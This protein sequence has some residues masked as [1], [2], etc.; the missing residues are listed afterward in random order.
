MEISHQFIDFFTLIVFIFFKFNFLFFSIL[1]FNCYLKVYWSLNSIEF[2]WIS[3][4]DV[5]PSLLSNFCFYIITCVFLLWASLGVISIPTSF[6]FKNSLYFLAIFLI[7]FSNSAVSFSLL[8]FFD[9]LLIF[10]FLLLS[11]SSKL[12]SLSYPA[13]NFYNFLISSSSSITLFFFSSIYYSLNLLF[14]SCLNFFFS[15]LYG[16]TAFLILRSLP[17]NSFPFKDSIACL[18]NGL[19]VNWIY[20]IPL[21]RWVNES[22]IT[23][24]FKMPSPYP[25]NPALSDFETPAKCLLKSSSF[26]TKGKFPIN[27]VV[28]KSF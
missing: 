10:T 1:P 8:I 26:N 16:A 17:I 7:W 14:S 22:L 9:L 15:N 6:F 3:N 20:A 5:F 2:L 12:S 27:I 11:S 23:L 19:L 28:S 4:F 21:P 24:T 25:P 13:V 18:I